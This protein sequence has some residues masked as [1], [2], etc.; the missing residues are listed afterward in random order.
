MKGFLTRFTILCATFR[1]A[2]MPNGSRQVPTVLGRVHS[3]PTT[4]LRGSALLF[5]LLDPSL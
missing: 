5:Q 3:R 1:Q 2:E 4:R